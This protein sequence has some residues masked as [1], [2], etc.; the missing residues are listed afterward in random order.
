[1]TLKCFFQEETPIKKDL[2]SIS[3]LIINQIVAVTI[4]VPV[5]VRR[6]L[7]PVHL[8]VVS[9]FHSKINVEMFFFFRKKH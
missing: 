5:S 3:V 2:V 4:M 6:V 1:M 9:S 7:I 8:L